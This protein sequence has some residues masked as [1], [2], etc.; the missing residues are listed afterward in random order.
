MKTIKYVE[1]P[2]IIYIGRIY[3]K[4]PELIEIF[5]NVIVYHFMM[6]DNTKLM[7][8]KNDIYETEKDAK[9]HL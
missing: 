4:V 7:L 1:R 6:H 5:N 9:K 8:Y 2:Y 3:H